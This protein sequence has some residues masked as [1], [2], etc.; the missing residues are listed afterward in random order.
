MLPLSL[1][2]PKPEMFPEGIYSFAIF[3]IVLYLVAGY[4]RSRLRSSALA[5][6]GYAPRM[7]P[8]RLPLGF[9][10]LWEAIAVFLTI[11]G[12]DVAVPSAKC[13]F[14]AN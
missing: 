5:K 11:T 3:G 7:I 12:T 4:V 6:L 10:T 13:Q 8:F 9:D 2:I 14:R 1:E